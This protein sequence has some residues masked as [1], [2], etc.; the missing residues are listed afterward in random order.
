MGL[1]D[2][3]ANVQPTR[4]GGRCGV[5]V[6]LERLE[7]VDAKALLDAMAG[8]VPSSNLAVVL[9]NNG[10]DIGVA[11]LQRHRRRTRNGDGCQCPV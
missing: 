11:S 6:L 7:P 4:K 9:R 3:L 5:A 2:E 8:D 1:A 10:Y